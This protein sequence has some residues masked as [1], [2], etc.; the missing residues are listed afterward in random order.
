MWQF[1]TVIR[2]LLKSTLLL[3]TAGGIFTVSARIQHDSKC[4]LPMDK[5]SLAFFHGAM[6][7]MVLSCTQHESPFIENYGLFVG[8]LLKFQL[9]KF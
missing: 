5:C 8:R 7:S 9:I 6:T 3:A 1:P 2:T 4:D